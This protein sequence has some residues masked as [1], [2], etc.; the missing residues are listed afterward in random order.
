MEVEVGREPILSCYNVTGR[1][2]RQNHLDVD[3]Y[4]PIDTKT[5]EC[6]QGPEKK[7]I[8]W[9]VKVHVH[10]RLHEFRVTNAKV[11]CRLKGSG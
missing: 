8:N 3:M 9:S 2:N 5:L 1:P 11:V 7:A 4:V 10:D 6:L